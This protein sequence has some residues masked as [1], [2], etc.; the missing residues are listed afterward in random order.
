MN[1]GWRSNYAR[2]RSYFLNVV[3]QYKERADIKVYLEILLSLATISIFSV[4]AL[5]PTLITIAGLIKEIETKKQTIE[6]IDT[7]IRKISQAQ[8]AYDQ[9]RIGVNLLLTAIPVKPSPDVYIRQIEG[10]SLDNQLP[11]SSINVDEVFVLGSSDQVNKKSDRLE[12]MPLNS[13]GLPVSISFKSDPLGYSKIYQSIKKIE[14]LRQIVK[15]D[16]VTFNADEDDE[17]GRV[18]VTS[19]NA[20]LPYIESEQSF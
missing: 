16:S 11:I 19:I 20:R 18:I 2:Y 17:S 3:N 9:Q 8:I 1:P 14:S 4:F 10:V 15:I 13:S 5:R 12:E 7:K 6:M